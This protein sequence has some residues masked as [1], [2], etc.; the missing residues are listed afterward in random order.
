MFNALASYLLGAPTTTNSTDE[1]EEN[2]NLRLTSV[3][4]DDD[5]VVVDRDDERDSIGNSEVESDLSEP[6]D[7][8]DNTIDNH[9]YLPC[10]LTRTSSVSSLPCTTI[11]ESWYITPPP[12]FTSAGPIV[13]E[14]SPLENL[15]IE[16]PSMSVYHQHSQR[17]N[18]YVRHN[19]ETV[20]VFSVEKLV[21]DE[22]LETREA[23]V[24]Q[25]Q[26]R[27][28]RNDRT[29]LVP[30][31]SR[32]DIIKQEEKQRLKTKQAQKVQIQKA[33]Q[34]LKRRYLERNNKAREVNNR[35]RRQRRGEKSQGANRSYANNN[36]KC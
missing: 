18:H 22:T 31:R 19:L 4:S 7:D 11:D 21:E 26:D 6:S 29:S 2:N 32:L 10:L 1:T 34:S 25:V 27:R 14:T 8:C 17:G 24:Q 13:M 12:C 33:C 16:H 15:L 9:H 30:H 3:V 20:P 35:N 36:R 5:W 23:P 28:P